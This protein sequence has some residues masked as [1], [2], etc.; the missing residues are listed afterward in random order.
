V[1]AEYWLR[2]NCADPER[3]LYDWGMMRLPRRMYGVG[4]PFVMEADDQFRNKRD[5][6]VIC[7]LIQRK[8]ACSQILYF[9]L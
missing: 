5:A 2:L 1:S 9:Y 4:D 6:E 8:I 3:Q 7:F